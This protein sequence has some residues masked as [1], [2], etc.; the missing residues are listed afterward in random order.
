MNQF[1]TILISILFFSFSSSLLNAQTKGITPI[2]NASTSGGATKAVIVGVS[3]YKNIQK[4]TYAHTDAQAFYNFLTSPA[5]GKV[6]PNNIKLL[7]NDKA[8]A[9]QIFAA[10]DWLLETTKEGETVI[11]YFSGHGDLETKTIRQNGFL[12]AQDCPNA[13][14]MSGGTVAI[15]YLQDYLLTLIQKNKAKVLLVTDAC[16]SGKLAGGAEGAKQTATALQEQWENIT[17]ILSSQ[18]GEL[19]YESQ[20]WNGGGGIFTYYMINGLVGMADRNKDKKISLTELFIYLSDNIPKETEF[21][22]NP[23]VTGNLNGTVSFVD[24]NALASLVKKQSINNPNGTEVAMRGNNDDFK[25]ILDSITY[26]KYEKFQA[27]IKNDFLIYHD[28]NNTDA[29]TIYQ[30]L[31]DKKEAA[32][33]LNNMKTALIASLQDKSQTVINQ[34]LKGKVNLV[35]DTL[36]LDSAYQEL[37]HAFQL[38]DE[39]YIT[40]KHIKGRYLYLKSIRTASNKEKETLLN[41]C[42]ALEPDAAHPYNYLATVDKYMKEYDKAIKNYQKAISLAPKWSYP[43]NNLGI[44]YFDKKD[45]DKAIDNYNKAIVLNPD[46][47]IL[48]SNLGNAYY[49][50]KDYPKAIENF[51]KAIK[52]KPNFAYA[53]NNLCNVYLELND[54]EKAELN[55]NKA[56]E[57]N[58]KYA[59]AYNNLGNVYNLK[60]EYDKSIENYNKAISFRANY[61][62]AY[63]NLGCIYNIKKDLD[64]AKLNFEKAISLNATYAGAYNNLG[65][66]Y[67]QQKQYDKAIENFDRAIKEAPEMSEAYW[68]L[69]CVYALTGNKAK[70]IENLDKALAKGFAGTEDIKTST[71]IDSIKGSVEF[72]AVMKKH[73]K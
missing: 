44:L 49:M 16:R 70:A 38:I 25:K 28:K 29:W 31:K 68:N 65:D 66:I 8:T 12:L 57:I 41:E 6:D 58:P 19:S 54:I 72:D 53:Y 22:Q 59:F 10:L 73:K 52:T 55:A 30:E 43:Y 35:R 67:K 7:L 45:Y 46:D 24:S 60:K 1:K 33:V 42:I 51:N 62:V 32:P 64:N 56:L 47:E 17:K 4:L 13:S 71:D 26:K 37:S 21:K 5:G 23:Y 27:C 15:N 11:F 39:K 3:D 2:E 14:Y 40:Y 9:G 50:K 69:C 63:F 36:I 34:I 18:A 20:K 61:D 48:Y